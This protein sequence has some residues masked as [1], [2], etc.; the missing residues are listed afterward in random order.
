[1]KLGGRKG[2]SER[3]TFAKEESPWVNQRKAIPVW[4]G[5]A[6]LDSAEMFEQ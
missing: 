1:M 4:G 5:D 6:E 2:L 3:K